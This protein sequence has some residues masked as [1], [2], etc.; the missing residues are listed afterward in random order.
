MSHAT[1]AE[2]V[3]QDIRRKTRRRFSAEEKMRMVLEGLRGEER[4]AA[5]YRRE[6]R[7]PNLYARWCQEVLE[8]GKKRLVGDTPR[9]A[10]SNA[11]TALRQDVAPRKPV[12]AEL[13]LEKRLLQHA[14]RASPRRSGRE[15]PG[16]RAGR[17]H[18]AGRRRGP[19]CA[20]VARPGRP[21]SLGIKRLSPPQGV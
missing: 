8:A 16:G 17:G 12:V 13:V 1:S 4:I 19:P 9:A 14:C 5:R 20:A 18:P 11:V 3:V 6:G 21:W 15:T 2:T 7:T 10:T